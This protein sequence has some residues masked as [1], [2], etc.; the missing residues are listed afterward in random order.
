MGFQLGREVVPE[1]LAR[2][3]VRQ[4]QLEAVQSLAHPAADLDEAQAHSIQLQ[5]R[6]AS[7]HEPAPNGIQEPVGSGVQQQAELVGPEA[8][9]A[10]AI[11]KAGIL[12][13]LDPLLG[14][15]TL[16]VPIVQSQWLLGGDRVASADVRKNKGSPSASWHCDAP[17]T[18]SILR[19]Q[20]AFRPPRVVR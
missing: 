4:V 14:L 10:E 17:A 1:R 13:V 18:R 16:H 6:H 3:T 12:E 11:G 8:M 9:A 5:A 15:A 20:I 19:E 7:L 2:M